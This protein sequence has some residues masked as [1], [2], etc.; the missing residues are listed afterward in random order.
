METCELYTLAHLK[1]VE[2]LTLLTVS[3]S[4]LTG[5]QVSSKDRQSTFNAMIDLALVTL[6]D[7]M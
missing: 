5:E 7:E 2:A 6:F 4:L 3:D 1:Q